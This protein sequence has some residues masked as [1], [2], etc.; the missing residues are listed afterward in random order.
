MYG[1][2][3][4]TGL[5]PDSDPGSYRDFHVYVKSGWLW[6]ELETI[7]A[8]LIALR[9][10]RFTFLVAPL[11][12]ILWYMS[13]DLAPML[14][15]HDL[16]W[17]DRDWVSVAV[18]AVMLGVAYFVDR[19]TRDDYAFWLYLFGLFAFWGGMSVMNSDSQLNRFIYCL[20]NVFMIIVSVL[21][22]RRAFLVF[23]ALGV[24]GYLGYL[25]WHVFQDSIAFPFALSFIGLLILFSAVKYARN[26]AAIDA[27]MIAMVPAWLR[28]RLP[29]ARVKL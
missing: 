15:G 8:S 28:S 23:G 12:F 5:W 13:M 24:T 4:A 27:R 2:E 16:S 7:L 20:I 14:F 10:V 18:G 22:E 19:R 21:L 3:R 25:S 17:N 1:L 11:A 9:F 29:R 6:M 26:R